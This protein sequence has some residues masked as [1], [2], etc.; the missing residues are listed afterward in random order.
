[1]P[2]DFFFYLLSFFLSSPNLS[3]RRLDV[4]HTCIHGVALVR[5]YN[6]G[7]KRT[8]SGSLKIQ[9]SKNRQKSP[10]R[11]HRTN[12]SVCIFVNEVYMDN[13]KMLNSNTSSTCPENMVNFGPLL[14]SVRESG[15]ALQRLQYLPHISTQHKM[16]NFGPLAAKIYRRVWGTT[17]NFNGFRV[18]AALLHGTVVVGVSR[19]LRR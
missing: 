11:H 12:L 19:T 3:G 2:C 16:V 15:A 4:Y 17:A 9:D 18:L 6:A 1:L 5:I 13:R 14:R 7:L 10:S 8:A